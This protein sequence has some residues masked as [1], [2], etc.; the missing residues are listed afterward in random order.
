MRLTP[1]GLRYLADRPPFPFNL[2]W[3][4]PKLCG[5][6]RR[7]WSVVTRG[8]LV[9]STVLVVLLAHLHL[10]WWPSVAAGALVAG[11]P[12]LRFLWQHTVLVDAPALLLALAS[13]VACGHHWYPVATVLAVVAGLTMERAPVFA[14][15]FAWHPLPLVGLAAPLIVALLRR[16]GPDV[17][18]EANAWVLEHPIQAARK[19]HPNWLDPLVMLTPWG[20]CLAGLIDPSPQ[21]AATVAVGY[22]QLAVA[23]D[24]VRLYQWAAPVLAIAAVGVIPVPWL[25]L[26]VV[27]HWCNPLAGNGV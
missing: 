3:L 19:F 10:G 24:S 22:S 2:R 8:S 20:V 25:L 1:D 6:R 7:R 11:L 13:A 21:V 5:S 23:T 9:G 14:A 15:L 27:A 18:D 12:S 16:P 17:L 4:A 26:A